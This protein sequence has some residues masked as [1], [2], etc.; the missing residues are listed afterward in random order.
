ME[1]LKLEIENFK[2]EQEMEVL[3]NSSKLHTRE[4]KISILPIENPQTLKPSFSL[5][6]LSENQEKI[7]VI[8]R[9]I[10]R[11]KSSNL[12][13]GIFEENVE[14]DEKENEEELVCEGISQLDDYKVPIPF[15]KTLYSKTMLNIMNLER[16]DQIY[17]REVNEIISDI[18]LV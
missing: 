16:G 5:T 1:E 4:V 3:Q 2:S 12:L 8:P 13:L 7:N 9:V 11:E 18:Q 17:L 15:P 14:R 6:S 10:L